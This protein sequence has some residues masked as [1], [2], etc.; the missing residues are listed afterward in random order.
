MN[1]LKKFSTE[2]EY[3]QASL[4]YP[5]VSWVTDTDNVH[6]DK[7][8]S[9]PTVND[10]VMIASYGGSGENNF[11]F[12]NCEASS[13]SDITSITLDDVAVEPITCKT[14]SSY[15]AE[16]V[17]VAK[18]TLNTTTVGYWCADCKVWRFSCRYC[19]FLIVFYR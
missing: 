9:T 7:S 15:D 4:N 2:A 1:N 8:G 19:R 14:E 5:A 13:S 12:Y 17:H 11:I 10:K 16:Q 3:Q 6:F 18:Y